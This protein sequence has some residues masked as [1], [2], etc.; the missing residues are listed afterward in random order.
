MCSVLCTYVY[1]S[2][3]STIL[4]SFFKEGF[5]MCNGIVVHTKSMESKDY[6]H[7]K[8]QS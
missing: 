6:L 5:G 3:T 7:F 2:D 8:D 4:F 1:R